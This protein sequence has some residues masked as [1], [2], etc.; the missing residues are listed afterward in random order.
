MS[1][2]ELTTV[3]TLFER[4]LELKASLMNLFQESRQSSFGGY[5]C[6]PQLQLS[7][8]GSTCGGLKQRLAKLHNTNW[9]SGGKG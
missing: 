5:V 3:K 1:Y 2:S 6:R 9:Y 4:D 7:F 8:D